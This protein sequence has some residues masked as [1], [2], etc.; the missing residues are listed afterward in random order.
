MRGCGSPAAWRDSLAWRVRVTASSDP[1]FLRARAPF[2]AYLYTFFLRVWTPHRARGATLPHRAEAPFFKPVA[3][4]ITNDHPRHASQAATRSTAYL[5]SAKTARRPAEIARRICSCC[6]QP[7][8][9]SVPWSL[10]PFG[11]GRR[12]R[13]ATEPAGAG[14]WSANARD[15]NVTSPSIPSS[16]IRTTTHVPRL[17]HGMWPPAGCRTGSRQC[18]DYRSSGRGAGGASARTEASR[19][20]LCSA[21][22]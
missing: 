9:P 2:F 15:S 14:S 16:C 11:R 10:G 3:T 19:L 13:H 1:L 20:R 21:P 6:H 4:V 12:P 5:T 7:L 17:R 18:D 8:D 22:A